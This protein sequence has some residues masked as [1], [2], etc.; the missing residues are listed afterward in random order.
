[1]P[2]TNL[3]WTGRSVE[4]FTADSAAPSGSTRE[5]PRTRTQPWRTLLAFAACALLLLAWFPAVG[6]AD[7]EGDDDAGRSDDG[8]RGPRRAGRIAET[9]GRFSGRYVQFG[10]DEA[11]CTVHDLR[12]YDLTVFDEV[13]LAGECD[14]ARPGS[15]GASVRLRSS[16]ARID[17]H[18]APNGLVRIDAG[19]GDTTLS[20]PA[21]ITAA[22]LSDHL[23]LLAGNVSGTF[24]LHD[25]QPLDVQGDTLTVR[26]T[27]GSFWIHPIQGGSPERAEIRQHI[28]NGIIAGEIDVLLEDGTV[29][30]EILTYDAVDIRAAKR[31]D[32]HFRFIVDANLTE[33]RV[34]V[35]NLGP[36]VFSSETIGVRYWDVEN[37]SDLETRIDVA[38]TLEDVLTIAAGEGAEY[39]VVDDVAGRHV[40]VAVPHF[41]VHIFDVLAFTGVAKPSIAAGV[42][43]GVA[44]VALAAM[45]MVPRRPRDA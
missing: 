1:M 11:T 43:L 24:R 39:W 42:I 13:R 22:I 26:D 29:T 44:F 33:G 36:G 25:D 41:S 32:G 18:D 30:N 28:R 40:L 12:V 38:D 3:P 2:Y 14:P 45:G 5:K 37:G 35:V 27:E 8:E 9:D 16:L 15:Q 6:L 10:F 19:E 20:W 17:I 7:S 31:S 4:A 23:E 34:F 21:A